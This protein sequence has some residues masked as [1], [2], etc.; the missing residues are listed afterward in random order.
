MTPCVFSRACRTAW[1]GAMN[2]PVGR[3]QAQPPG[4]TAAL[5]APAALAFEMAE[6][7]GGAITLRKRPD[8][9]VEDRTEFLPSQLIEFLYACHVLR[10][11][12]TL[13]LCRGLGP[14]SQGNAL[15]H[16]VQ[17]AAERL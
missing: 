2:G 8:F 6:H 12:F 5:R 15:R 7:H 10:S 3:T 13:A 1:R 4:I 17:P 16:T 14:G 11:P 9:L